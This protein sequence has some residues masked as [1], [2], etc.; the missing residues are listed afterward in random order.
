VVKFNDNR[1]SGAPLAPALA[2]HAHR[3]A[4]AMAVS[5]LDG[6]M[7]LWGDGVFMRHVFSFWFSWLALLPAR[8]S[9]PA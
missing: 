2:L 8:F 1:L 7:H 4:D 3:R 6:G 9:W 5:Q